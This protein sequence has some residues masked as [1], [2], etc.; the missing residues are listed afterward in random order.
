MAP[1]SVQMEDAECT[2][3]DSECEHIYDAS[4][5]SSDVSVE[6]LTAVDLETLAASN[7]NSV[8]PNTYR[9]IS[10]EDVE[11]LQ[12][13]AGH[14]VMALLGCTLSA[15]KSVLMHYRWSKEKLANALVERDVEQVFTEC[16]VKIEAKENPWALL[17]ANALV[18]CEICCGEERFDATCSMD[19]GHSFCNACWRLHIKTQIDDGRARD[20][21][22]MHFKCGTK[23]GQEKLRGLLKLLPG[24]LIKYEQAYLSS[25]LEENH[26]VRLCP[27]VPWCGRAIQVEGEALQEPECSCG[28][29][30]CF[31]C[32]RPP[33]SPCTCHIW[34]IWNEK[35]TVDSGTYDWIAAHT[36]PCP[37]C[38]KAVEK[39]GGCNHV[40][41]KCG[42]AF[43]WHCGQATKMSH[44]WDSIA[45]HSCGRYKE[46]AERKVDEAQRNLQ[47]YM[48]YFERWKDHA[49]SLVKEKR[50][51]VNLLKLIEDECEDEGSVNTRDIGWL[52]RAMEQ[53]KTARGVLA[54][55]YPFAYIFFGNDLYTSEFS[56][57][58]TVSNQQL[59]EDQQQMLESEVERLS[60]LITKCKEDLIVETKDYNA[61]LRLRVINSSVSIQD[62]IIKLYDL[63]EH[64]LY[65]KLHSRSAEITS[66]Q[67]KRNL[68]G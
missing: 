55:S 37:K 29:T 66:Y 13:E 34:S 40:T 21:R 49:D 19:C 17:P 48:H 52:M 7:N 61:E 10:N 56:P 60:A 22:C 33:H 39:D 65:G 43:C 2:E 63:I 38:N 6:D 54:P 9:I 25:Y 16:G 5:G 26:R 18:M 42:Q 20:L 36:K 46:E 24:Y 58:Q 59:F 11:A 31:K 51:R 23:C 67:P 41:C 47:R 44:T 64:D 32:G 8:G 45:D 35:T 12:D 57:E 3:D 50:E 30:F 1:Q 28:T 27:S 53:L 15:A 14:E 68:A 62:R 4:Y